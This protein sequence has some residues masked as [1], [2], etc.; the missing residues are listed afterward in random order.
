MFERLRSMI[1]PCLMTM[2]ADIPDSLALDDDRDIWDRRLPGSIDE[3]HVLN[4]ERF[5]LAQRRGCVENEKEKNRQEPL[6]WP[7]LSF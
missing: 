1:L 6:Q 4:N 2:R 7:P 3:R 5:L